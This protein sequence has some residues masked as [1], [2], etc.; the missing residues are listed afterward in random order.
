[1]EHFWSSGIV[2]HFVQHILSLTLTVSTL[3]LKFGSLELSKLSVNIIQSIIILGCQFSVAPSLSH[4]ESDA[5]PL[6][7]LM[8]KAQ[9]PL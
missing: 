2:P 8:P 3:P 4:Y 5:R 9:S 7:S 6:L 1:M